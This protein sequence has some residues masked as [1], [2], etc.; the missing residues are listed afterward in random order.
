[1]QARTSADINYYGTLNVTKA[2]LPLMPDGSRIINVSSRA[3]LLKSLS[4]E[5]QAKFTAPDLTEE[6]ISEVRAAR[7]E[8]SLR[9]RECSRAHGVGGCS[10]SR[11]S[12]R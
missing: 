11:S 7:L 2:V 10:C 8:A 12:S 5:L 9:A 3:G 6:G 1:M 4:P